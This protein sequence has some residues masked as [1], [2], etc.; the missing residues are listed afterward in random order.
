M[1]IQLETSKKIF[2]ATGPV[3][4]VGG[5]WSLFY[6]A[7]LMELHV[8]EAGWWFHYTNRSYQ[9]RFIFNRLNPNHTLTIYLAKISLW[10]FGNTGIG[11]RFPV[12]FFGTLSAGALYLFVRKVT[13]SSVTGVSPRHCFF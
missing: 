12:I 6:Y 3:A 7:Y 1:N 10:M 2:Y 13:G 5:I 9:H 8:D 11:L 4:I